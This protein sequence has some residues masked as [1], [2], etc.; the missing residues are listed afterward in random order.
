MCESELRFIRSFISSPQFSSVLYVGSGEEQAGWTAAAVVVEAGV[1]GGAAGARRGL[2]P[3]GAKL[4]AQ[5]V[6]RLGHPRSGD[7][8]ARCQ[9]RRP[10]AAESVERSCGSDSARS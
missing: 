4:A 3:W 9:G 1:G 5:L 6:G 10:P 8:E 7:E 2:L